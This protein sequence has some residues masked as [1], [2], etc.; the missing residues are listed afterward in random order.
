MPTRGRGPPHLQSPILTSQCSRCLIIPKKT[1]KK[2]NKSRNPRQGSL[3]ATPPR[4]Q[5]HPTRKQTPRWVLL[6]ASDCLGLLSWSLV[7][8]HGK[9]HKPYYNRT[10]YLYSYATPHLI[11]IYLIRVWVA[12]GYFWFV[13]HT[14]MSCRRRNKL[15]EICYLQCMIIPVKHP[16]LNG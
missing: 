16:W 6:A 11:D 12:I 9:H 3:Y 14:Y 7:P 8:V 10:I 2:L 5:G 1:Q 15:I 4:P 13:S